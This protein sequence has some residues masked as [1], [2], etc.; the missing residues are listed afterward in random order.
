MMSRSCSV[1]NL[2]LDKNA[3]NTNKL[4]LSNGD[5]HEEGMTESFLNQPGK[6][7]RNA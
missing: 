4:S 7:V 1:R 3:W 5:G 2:D 6:K